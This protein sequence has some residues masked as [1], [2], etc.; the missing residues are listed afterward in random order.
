M[1]FTTIS[2]WGPNAAMCHYTA[3]ETEKSSVPKKG[4]YLVDSG[5]QYYEGTTDVTRTIAV[6]PI[7]QEEK[8][9][10]TLVACS[11]L[12]LLDAKFMYGCRGINLDYIARELLWKTAWISI[13]EQ[14]MASAIWAVCM[15]ARI[16]SDGGCSHRLLKMRFWRKVW[17]PLMSRVFIWKENLASGRRI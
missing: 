1:S 16:P 12:R 9:C 2:A 4:L 13:T 7:T 11:M 14:G 6:G 3:S 8:R 17:L 5:G 15:S 10:C